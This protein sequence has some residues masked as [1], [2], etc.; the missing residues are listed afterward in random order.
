M[1]GE[2]SKPVDLR[3]SRG[4]VDVQH[5]LHCNEHIHVAAGTAPFY[6]RLRAREATRI[7]MERDRNAKPERHEYK[8]LATSAEGI[9]R[10]R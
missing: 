2:R 5:V 1:E 7:I 8:L 4:I 6:N 3:T 9:D 10:S